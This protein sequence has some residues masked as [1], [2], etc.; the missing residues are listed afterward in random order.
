MGGHSGL[1]FGHGR[2]A[3]FVDVY[4]LF[5]KAYQIA[6]SHHLLSSSHQPLSHH[7]KSCLTDKLKYMSVS[8]FQSSLIG[9]RESVVVEF[10]CPR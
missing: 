2:R 5:G 7:T 1:E 10:L 8:A 9:R 4:L 6:P 3:S